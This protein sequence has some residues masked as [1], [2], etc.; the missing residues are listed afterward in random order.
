MSNFD[1]DTRPAE[2]N[3]RAKWLCDL[4]QIVSRK[5]DTLRLV[6]HK[7]G[8][9]P[10]LAVEEQT[11]GVAGRK[12]GAVFPRLTPGAEERRAASEAGR[13]A[14]EVCEAIP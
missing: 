2:G 8:D 12:R 1:L 11:D 4:L 5:R 9:F 3:G 10:F 6:I 14:S 7:K 13:Q